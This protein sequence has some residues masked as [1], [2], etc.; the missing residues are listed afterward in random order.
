M[1]DDELTRRLESLSRG[2]YIDVYHNSDE[3][4]LKREHCLTCQSNNYWDSQLFQPIH[5]QWNDQY[6]AVPS[7]PSPAATSSGFASTHELAA[8][9]TEADLPLPDNCTGIRCIGPDNH[10]GPFLCAKCQRVFYNIPSL[11]KH[12]WEEKGE[13]RCYNI[14]CIWGELSVKNSRL[15]GAWECTNSRG[16]LLNLFAKP[17]EQEGFYNGMYYPDHYEPSYDEVMKYPIKSTYECPHK[18]CEDRWNHMDTTNYL[19]MHLQIEHQARPCARQDCMLRSDLVESFHPP[20]KCLI[21]F[22]TPEQRAVRLN[23]ASSTQGPVHEDP[24]TQAVA[25]RSERPTSQTPSASILAKK[26]KRRDSDTDSKNGRPEKRATQESSSGTFVTQPAASKTSGSTWNVNGKKSTAV[27]HAT[28]DGCEEGCGYLNNQR[29]E[30][31]GKARRG[32]PRKD[33]MARKEVPPR[34]QN[35]QRREQ[36]QNEPAA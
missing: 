10:S 3:C 23:Q 24:Q 9:L 25:A 29:R 7:E 33:E 28:R 12:E 15:H 5:S 2:T 6:T 35:R 30:K 8:R 26:S 18:Y 19:A 4:F 32:R 16:Y 17:H 31:E 27:R 22:E 34:N 13:R 20:E 14:D 36:P 11:A 1:D 21:L